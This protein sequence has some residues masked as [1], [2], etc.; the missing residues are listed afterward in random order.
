MRTVNV[1]LSELSAIL[2]SVELDSF[3]ESKD[4]I[5]HQLTS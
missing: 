4:Y 1:F 3:T 5:E 2:E